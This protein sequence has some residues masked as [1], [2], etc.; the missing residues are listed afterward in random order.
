[1][2]LLFLSLFL[3]LTTGIFAQNKPFTLPYE[4]DSNKTMTYEEIIGMCL[5]VDSLFMEVRL[6]SFGTSSGGYDLPYL[7]VEDPMRKDDKLTLWIQAGIHPGESE[8]AD[9]GFL[10]IRDVLTKSEFRPMLQKVRIIFIP[11]FNADGWNRFSPYNRIN[12][13][14][15][16]EM[17]WRC[18]AQN[19]NLN[20]D[21]MKADAPAMQNWLTLFNEIKPDFIVDCHTTDGA[22]YQ[23]ALTYGLDTHASLNQDIASWLNEEYIPFVDANMSQAGYP[24]FPYVAFRQ[25]HNP[26]S[27][28]V[29]RASRPMLS[30]GYTIL[31]DRPC[32][33]IETHM[34]KPYKNR[35]ESTRQ[36][37]LNTFILL[38]TQKDDY[39]EILK[40][41]D[42][43]R[44][45]NEFAEEKFPIH[46]STSMKDSTLTNFLGFK[47][48]TLTSQITGGQ[49]Y[50]YHNDQPEIF[51][52]WMFDKIEADQEIDLPIAYVIPLEWQDVIERLKLHG[53]SII[54]VQEDIVIEAI[55]I[56]FT[57][58]E[59][60]NRPYEGR[61]S[62]DF[63]MVEYENKV[64]VHKGSA[65]IPVKQDKIKIIA[66]LLEPLSDDSFL[67][68]GFFNT[69]FEQKEYGELYVMEPVAVEMFEKDPELKAEFEKL[70][71]ENPQFAA[72][73]WAQMNWVYNHSQWA[74]PQKDVY[75]VLKIT[76]ESEFKKLIPSR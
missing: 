11:V 29:Q 6:K 10:F 39:L 40:K 21:F 60:Q 48:D 43:K 8:G 76:K 55:Q 19:L 59:F 66:W 64:L 35:V 71:T 45:S 65:L 24:I 33:L 75:P 1:M 47:F 56:K 63:E 73:Q 42:T 57:N 70:K 68:W 67:K 34:L 31:V 52:L 2:R 13:N 27:G 17:G 38:N 25:W 14:G 72:S 23:Y 58:I 41:A 69:I 50:V 46:F 61:F 74:D 28:L 26:K 49:Y 53:I 37:L 20:R 22:D 62:P 16:E 3:I 15:P 51:N 36:M 18:T 5:T 12:Q 44:N 30:H 7:I 4:Q 54:T 32:L 9:A